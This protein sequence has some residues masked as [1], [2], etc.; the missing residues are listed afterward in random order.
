MGGGLD[1]GDREESMLAIMRRV[2]WRC[3]CWDERSAG[4]DKRY[5]QA[6]KHREKCKLHALG[7][8]GSAALC[9]VGLC[10]PMNSPG[11]SSYVRMLDTHLPTVALAR[12]SS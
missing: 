7:V 4:A 1:M 6:S 2:C 5:H 11:A 3:G 8:R 9:F 12:Q 10:G